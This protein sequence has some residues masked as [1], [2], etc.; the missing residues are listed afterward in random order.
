[1]SVREEFQDFISNGNM[2]DVAVGFVMGVIFR[3]LINSLVDNIIMPIVAIPFGEPNFDA[4]VWEINDSQITIGAFLTALVSFFLVAVGLFF[5][6]VKPMNA[7]RAR[8]QAEADAEPEAPS[9]IELLTQ[10]RDQLANR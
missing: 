3:D 6:F 4:I 9:E 8:Q 1:M 2:V 7:W 5:F 10:I